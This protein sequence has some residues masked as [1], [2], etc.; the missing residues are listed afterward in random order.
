MYHERGARFQIYN[1]HPLIDAVVQLLKELVLAHGLV[2]VAVDHAEN[3]HQQSSP[4]PSPSPQNLLRVLG[5][6]LHPSDSQQQQQ[7]KHAN[8][9]EKGL[10]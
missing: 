5:V 9:S 4:G 2:R 1:T 7:Q 10:N 6:I 8:T 3:Q